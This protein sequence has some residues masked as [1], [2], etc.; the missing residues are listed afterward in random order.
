LLLISLLQALISADRITQEDVA[1]VALPAVGDSITLPDDGTT[2]TV[3]QIIHTA[4]KIYDEKGGTIDKPRVD[5]IVS[6]SR[7]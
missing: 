3:K 4:A 6:E 5:I 2:H 1:L 7:S